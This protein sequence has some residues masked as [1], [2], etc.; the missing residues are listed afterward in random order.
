MTLKELE[1][2]SNTENEMIARLETEEEAVTAILKR[3]IFLRENTEYISS[4]CKE[5]ARARFACHNEK[6]TVTMP[7]LT[8]EDY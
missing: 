6:E 1:P 5:Q 2:L 7:I 3:R 8:Q 4:L